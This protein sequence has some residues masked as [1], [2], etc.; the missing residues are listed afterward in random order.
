MRCVFRLHHS[1]RGVT[2]TLVHVMRGWPVAA[3][4]Q[5]LP[6]GKTQSTDQLQIISRPLFDT[7]TVTDML[8]QFT[9]QYPLATESLWVKKTL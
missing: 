6:V 3:R 1:H 4:G 7:L 5:A 8:P 9:A 2:R